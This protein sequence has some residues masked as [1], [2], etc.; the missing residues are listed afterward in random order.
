M[1]KYL[2]HKYHAKPT[3]TD[4]IRYDSK[5]EAK[6]AGELKLRQMAGEVIFFLRQVPF[7][8][9]GNSTYRA[10]FMEFWSDGTVKIT[11]CKGFETQVWKLKKKLVES[12]YPIKI[13]IK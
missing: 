13:Q 11:E 6:Y 5:K 1:T 7:H 2:K 9:P 3:V 10:D 8:L 12:I 4:G